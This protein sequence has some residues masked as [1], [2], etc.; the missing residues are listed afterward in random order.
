ML[1]NVNINNGIGAKG[2]KDSQTTG[3]SFHVLTTEIS[4]AA[5]SAAFLVD[6]KILKQILTFFFLEHFPIGHKITY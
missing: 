6:Q 1:V 4:K 2:N 3:Y 5:T